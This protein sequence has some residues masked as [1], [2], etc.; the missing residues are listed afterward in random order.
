MPRHGGLL[1]TVNVGR[2]KV[3]MKGFRE[4]YDRGEQLEIGGM[5]ND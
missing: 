5:L 3:T 2:C 1:R 4:K